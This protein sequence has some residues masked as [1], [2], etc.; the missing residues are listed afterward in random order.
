M[1]KKKKTPKKPVKKFI[2]K[3][4]KAVSVMTLVLVLFTANGLYQIFMK[5]TEIIRFLG[6]DEP[7]NVTE[8]WD[9]YGHLFK[10]HQTSTLTPDFLAA[11]AQAESGGN[12][13]AGPDWKL[14]V[15]A[16]FA[17][18]YSPASSSLGLYQITDGFYKQAQKYCVVK[19]SV[20][21]RRPWY[22]FSTCWSRLVYSR[23]FPSHAI[24]MTSAYLTLTT[25]KILKRFGKH[26]AKRSVKQTVAAISHLCGKRV[27]YNYVKRNF[28]AKR[29]KK[30]GTH[31]LSR[32]IKRI[33]AYQKAFQRAEKL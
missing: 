30:C 4:W 1:P 10:R 9:S 2:A 19:G 23:L 28:K 16:N 25:N 18:I 14:R 26:K 6:F 15:T 32:Y 12:P 22:E 20:K 27:A 17:K 7:R 29:G 31:S 5:P 33:K 8:T 21:R 11:L 3:R 13:I 24:E